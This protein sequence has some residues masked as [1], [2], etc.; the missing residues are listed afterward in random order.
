[1]WDAPRTSSRP[2]ESSNPIGLPSI[3]VV[4]GVVLAAA[5]GRHLRR[6]TSTTDT[7]DL[8][9]GGAVVASYGRDGDASVLNFVSDAVFAPDGTVWLVDRGNRTLVHLDASFSPLATYTSL[10]D[11]AL[12][13][14]VGIESLSDGRLVVTDTRTG[15][16]LVT[17]ASTS[18]SPLRATTLFAVPD[19]EGGTI[20]IPLPREVAVTADDTILVHDRSNGNSRRLLRFSSD[21]AQIAPPEAITG[22]TTGLAVTPR[23]DVIMLDGA[24]RTITRTAADGTSTTFSFD[25]RDDGTIVV[26]S[27][28]GRTITLGDAASAS[29]SDDPRLTPG[30]IAVDRSTGDLVVG[31]PNQTQTFHVRL[32]GTIR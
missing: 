25:R 16:H 7:V 6:D 24:D 26:T 3:S 2:T 8:V 13:S 30:G 18:S 1:M 32:K 27:S 5:A 10:G 11:I 23:G 17:P 20:P 4:R 22:I 12:R 29:P 21:G 28:D 19:G 9:D 14:P 15:V 31:L